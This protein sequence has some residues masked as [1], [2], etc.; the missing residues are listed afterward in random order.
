MITINSKLETSYIIRN[1]IHKKE[2]ITKFR[3]SG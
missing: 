1:I 3:K 2:I